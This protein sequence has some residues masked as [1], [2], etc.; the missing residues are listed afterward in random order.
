MAR[1]TFMQYISLNLNR[2]FSW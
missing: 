1:N 2:L